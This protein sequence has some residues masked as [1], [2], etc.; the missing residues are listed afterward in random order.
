MT[1]PNLEE[2]VYV[3]V[4]N[5]N[6]LPEGI[7]QLEGYVSPASGGIPED[8]NIAGVK[9]ALEDDPLNAL[10]SGPNDDNAWVD[11]NAE[12]EPEPDPV[13]ASTSDTEDEKSEP[14]ESPNQASPSLL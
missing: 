4:T 9:A 7:G 12:P 6:Y 14:E 3:P 13:A 1:E 5:S 11:P 2:A 10:T 8:H